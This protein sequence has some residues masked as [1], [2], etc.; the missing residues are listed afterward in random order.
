MCRGSHVAQNSIVPVR[1]ARNKDIVWDQALGLCSESVP[2]GKHSAYSLRFAL[3]S[4]FT[5]QPLPMC[6]L[7][8]G[9]NL[10]ISNEKQVQM[11]TNLLNTL[12][13]SDVGR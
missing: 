11:L 3:R 9:F 10:N 8:F 2:T 7:Q 13:A 4:T 1:L 5:I 6:W 12:K